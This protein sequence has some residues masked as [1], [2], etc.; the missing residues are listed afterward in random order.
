MGSQILR[1]PP[2]LRGFHAILVSSQKP[3]KI[4]GMLYQ[5]YLL[6]T[7][8]RRYNTKNIEYHVLTK[9]ITNFLILFIIEIIQNA[10]L[11]YHG[12]GTSTRRAEGELGI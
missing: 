8:F 12:E 5:E 6:L 3:R 2:E 9:I 11:N 7:Q 1:D 4:G 10:S